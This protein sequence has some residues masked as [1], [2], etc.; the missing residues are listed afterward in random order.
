MGRFLYQPPD[1]PLAIT[2]TIALR[3]ARLLFT[4]TRWWTG[5]SAGIKQFP[6]RKI[7]N[8]VAVETFRQGTH[9]FPLHPILR[10]MR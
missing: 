1:C 5:S 3:T 4:T 10:P 2:K 7:A 6:W 8:A 9:A